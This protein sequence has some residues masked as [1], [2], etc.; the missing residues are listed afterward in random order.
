MDELKQM[1]GKKNYL[2]KSMRAQLKSDHG[3]IDWTIG[4]WY[5]EKTTIKCQK[6]FH[7]SVRAIDAMRYVNCEILCKVEVKGKSDI[8]DDKQC[9]SEMRIEKAYVWKKED[10]VALAIYAAELVIDI[11]EKEVPKDKR[12][13]KAIEAA[14]KWLK[15]PTEKNRAAAYT[16]AYAAANAA[17]YAANAANATYAAYAAAYAANAANAARRVAPK[18]IL[19]QC[20]KWVIDRIKTL[21]AYDSKS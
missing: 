13:R 15:S 19:D 6:G 16:A 21:E 8:D 2:W 4:K 5:E 10:S 3:N 1:L 7:A 11:F 20:N 18:K 17:A 14:K 9:W 12:P